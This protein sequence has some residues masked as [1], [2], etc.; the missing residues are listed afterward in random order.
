MTTLSSHSRVPDAF[1]SETEEFSTNKSALESLDSASTGDE[2]NEHDEPEI[3]EKDS[4]EEELERLLFGES[5]DFRDQ[6]SKF[7]DSAK[8]REWE[9][10]VENDDEH[11]DPGLGQLEDADVS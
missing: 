2:H 8:N 7:A 5:A 3:A 10:S 9:P 4:E 11:S 6:L 1:Q